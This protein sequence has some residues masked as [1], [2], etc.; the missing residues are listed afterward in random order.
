MLREKPIYLS[1]DI[2][3]SA[4]KG[5]GVQRLIPWQ[6]PNSHPDY[7]PYQDSSAKDRMVGQ[8]D[9]GSEGATILG[10][11]GQASGSS[12]PKR[13]E[14]MVLVTPLPPKLEYSPNQ[15]I[16]PPKWVPQ[17]KAKWTTPPQRRSLPPTSLQLKY[18]GPA[19][20]SLP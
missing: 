20:M 8:H 2:L 17:M 13:L 12:T 7:Q 9:H 1:V 11:S 4:T 10:T 14:P 15:W 6:S 5:G 16:H 19:V 3:Q 18:Q